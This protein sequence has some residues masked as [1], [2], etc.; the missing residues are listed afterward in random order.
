MAFA[1]TDTAMT[2][3]PYLRQCRLERRITLEAVA[4]RTKIIRVLRRSRAQQ[5]VEVARE[6]FYREIY[7][8][9]YASAVG[10]DPQ[11]VVDRYRVEFEGVKAMDAPPPVVTPVVRQRARFGRP[12]SRSLSPY[13][14]HCVLLGRMY[15]PVPV[16]IEA[17]DTNPAASV[18]AAPTVRPGLRRR[19]QHRLR[20]RVPF[21]FQ[22]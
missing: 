5:S 15:A 8:R 9:A 6:P 11:D 19:R 1:V 22:P 16:S 12:P 13:I 4:L 18:P 21:A 10:L 17:T 14:H 2:L 7:L 20:T 3:G